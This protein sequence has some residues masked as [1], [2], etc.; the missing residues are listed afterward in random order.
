MACDVKVKILSFFGPPGSGKGTVARDC[1]G[2]LGYT[3]LSTGD[4]CRFHIREQTELGKKFSECVNSGNLIPDDLITEVVVKWLKEK[5]SVGLYC[6]EDKELVFLLDGFPRT[7]KQ[8]ELFLDSLN[9][10]ETLK[11]ICFSVVNF[12]L[13]EEKIIKRISNRVVCGN[14]KCQAIYSVSISPPKEEGVCDLCGSDLLRREDDSEKV[15]RDRLKVFYNFNN[16]LISFYRDFGVKV[17]D[18]QVPE[19]D[20][21]MVFEEF[22][23]SL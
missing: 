2:K 10:D 21:D 17:I 19:G 8:A 5:V 9:S 4:L 12:D 6:D 20:P 7:K 1:V 23:S 15:V 18:F 22:K 13:K 14:Q 11:N 3:M 16:Q